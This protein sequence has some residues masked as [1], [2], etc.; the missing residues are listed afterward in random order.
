MSFYKY[1]HNIDNIIPTNV[2]YNKFVKE[3]KD[4]NMKKE[5]NIIL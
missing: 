5:Y 4:K 1:I 2:A 3:K